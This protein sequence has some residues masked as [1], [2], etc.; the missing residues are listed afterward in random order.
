M[1]SLPVVK[2]LLHP[3]VI[4]KFKEVI[5]NMSVVFFKLSIIK[6]HP[7]KLKNKKIKKRWG[8]DHMKASRN[9]SGTHSEPFP[10]FKSCHSVLC[11]CHLS[12]LPVTP[13]SQWNNSSYKTATGFTSENSRSQG[14][15]VYMC[16]LASLLGY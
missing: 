8:R 14:G 7:S 9:P 1:Y 2:I 3:K 12:K 13:G 4:L 11:N 15:H 16:V 10:T 6:L 5:K